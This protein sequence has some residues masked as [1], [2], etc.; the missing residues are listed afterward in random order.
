MNYRFLKIFTFLYF[1]PS[2]TPKKRN[3]KALY[4]PA[5]ATYMHYLSLKSFFLTLTVMIPL[6]NEITSSFQ[7][8]PNILSSIISRIQMNQQW[9]CASVAHSNFSPEKEGPHWQHCFPSHRCGSNPFVPIYD[10]IGN[11]YQA[12][13]GKVYLP[14]HELKFIKRRNI[15]I[16]HDKSISESKSYY[17]EI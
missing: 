16:Y 13:I 3:P 2:C 12:F 4:I 10:L 14:S 5:K 7:M 8:N 17:H 9:F 1:L 15:N 6:D 11:S